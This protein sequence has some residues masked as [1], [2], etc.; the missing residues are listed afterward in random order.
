MLLAMVICCTQLVMARDGQPELPPDKINL[1]LRRTA[2]KLLRSAG[3]DH[4]RIPA[5]KQISENTWRV[6][7]EHPFSYDTLPALL[8]SSLDM[9]GIDQAYEVAIRQCEGTTIDLGY[10][11]LDFLQDSLV[12]CGGRTAPEGCHYLDVTFLISHQS[13]ASWAR[14]GALLCLIFLVAFGGWWWN[15]RRSK[16]IM[17]QPTDREEEWLT[18]G[19]SR[20][21]LAGQVLECG[22]VR[23]PLTYREAKLLRLFASH[24]DQLLE[25]EH[26]LGQVW[27]DEGVQVGRSIDMF[28]SRLRKKLKADPT[29]GIVAVHGLGYRL[30]TGPSG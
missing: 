18:F 17:V 26:I 7:L 10:H 21:H 1:A 22:S 3:D 16:P 4:S 23:H 11:Q 6:Y 8:Q 29:V 20:L 25:R 15:R 12:P 28:V 14:T 27:A 9:Y 24:P 30:E 13:K 19:Q 5:V 2:D